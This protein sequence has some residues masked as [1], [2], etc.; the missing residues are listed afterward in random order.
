MALT[1]RFVCRGNPVW[2]PSWAATQGR[3]YG[4]F[5]ADLRPRRKLWAIVLPFYSAQ[6]EDLVHALARQAWAMGRQLHHFVDYNNWEEER[7]L[8]GYLT[9]ERYE[10][11]VVVPTPSM[12][13]ARSLRY[14]RSR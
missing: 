1:A 12:L 9:R 7:R 6:Y 14:S 8:V 2:L 4:S 5:V 13:L 11:V 3:P 10:A